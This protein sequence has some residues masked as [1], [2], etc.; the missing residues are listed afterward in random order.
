M[1]VLI[2]HQDIEIPI[3]LL[4]AKHFYHAKMIDKFLLAFFSLVMEFHLSISLAFQEFI[5]N[6]MNLLIGQLIL[7]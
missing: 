3:K 5:V 1:N 4:Y 7:F 6:E 2:D